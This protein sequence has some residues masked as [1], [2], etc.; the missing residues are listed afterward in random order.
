MLEFFTPTNS[1]RIASS[2]HPVIS[3][4]TKTGYI[5]LN[6]SLCEALGLK[7]DYSAFGAIHC[8]SLYFGYI[9]IPIYLFFKAAQWWFA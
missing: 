8:V 1:S 4:G 9:A 3:I 7:E 2:K 5:Q 6:C